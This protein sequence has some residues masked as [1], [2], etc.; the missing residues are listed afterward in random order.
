MRKPFLMLMGRPTA[1]VSANLMRVAT[2]A[3]LVARL[4]NR[5]FDAGNL[6]QSFSDRHDD[7]AATL[8]R[9]IEVGDALVSPAFDIRFDRVTGAKQSRIDWRFEPSAG[10]TP[11]F[12]GVLEAVRAAFDQVAGIADPVRHTPHI[13]FGYGAP[14]P[15]QTMRFPPVV[16][17]VERIELVRCISDPYRYDTIASWDLLLPTHHSAAQAALF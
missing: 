2:A 7:S 5:L 14:A 3:G 15:I 1:S 16:W 11:E 4:G 6:H 10:K 17:T 9:L 12:M 13:T 8:R